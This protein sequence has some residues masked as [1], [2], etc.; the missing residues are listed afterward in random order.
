MIS[1]GQ[2]INPFDFPVFVEIMLGKEWWSRDRNCDVC[3]IS[4]MEDETFIC[5]DCESSMPDRDYK[6]AS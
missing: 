3:G 2:P 6:P 4:L 1:H 5:R